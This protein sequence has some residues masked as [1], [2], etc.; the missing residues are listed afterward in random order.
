MLNLG[1]NSFLSED[2]SNYIFVLPPKNSI[3][4]GGKKKKVTM[5]ALTDRL[6]HLK[7]IYSSNEVMTPCVSALSGDVR[8][9]LT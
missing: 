5:F 7:Q 3:T 4:F 8:F 1:C 2:I 9:T 6:L